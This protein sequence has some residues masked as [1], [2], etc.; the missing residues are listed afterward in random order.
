VQ[1]NRG[2]GQGLIEIANLGT[3][4]GDLGRYRFAS[5]TDTATVPTNTFVVPAGK[6]VVV[7]V[8]KAGTQ[9]A[10]DSLFLPTLADLPTTGSLALYA[11][12]TANATAVGGSASLADD[13][14]ILDYLEWGPSGGQANETTASSAGVWTA[15]Q[16]LAA[17]T[18]GQGYEFCGMSGQFGAPLWTLV[19]DPDFGSSNVCTTPTLRSTWGK[20]KLM[21]R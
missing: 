15:S 13:T 9:S 20:L 12:N 3:A 11:P 6:R 14:Q 16:V 17:A 18:A 4:A 1:Y 19:T 2:S 5:S 10:P 8:N 7:H 21:Y